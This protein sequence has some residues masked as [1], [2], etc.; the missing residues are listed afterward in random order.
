MKTYNKIYTVHAWKDN[1]KFFTVTQGEGGIKYP[2]LMVVDDKGAID[3]TG[4]A[5]TYTITLPRGSEEIVDAT[6]IDGKRGVVEFEVKPSMTVYAG[7]GEGEL[8]ITINNKVLKI[9]GINLTI[10]KSTSGHVIEA[11]EQFSAL[12]TLISKYSNINPE[13]KDLKILDNSDITDTA[14]NYPSIKYLLNNFWSNNNFSLLSATAYGVSNSGA[15]TSLLKIP[16]ASLSKR[17]LYFPAG[18]Y[19]CNGIVLSNIDDL[20]I[21]CDNANFVFYNQATNSTDA[22]ETTVQGSFFKFSNCNNL[23][24]IG[25]CFDGQHKVSQC[26]TLVGCQNSNITNAT[27]KGAGNKASSFAAGINLIRDCSQFNINN[28]IVSDIKAGTVSEDTFIHAVGIGVSS[29]NGEFSQHGYI[30]NSQISNING[31][32]VGNK[33]PDGDGIY[34]IQRPSADCSGDSYITVSNCTI[35]DCA[36]RGIKVSTRYTNID[37]CYI[38]IDG[39]GAA[40]EAQYGKMTLRDSTIH[41]KYASCVTL[42]WDN[43]T[44]YIDNCKL[45]GADKTETSTHGDKYTGN[46]IVLNQR[47]SVTG[48][49]YTNEPCSVI[50]RHCTIENVTSPLRSGYAAGLTYQYQSIIFD[51]CQIGHYRGA[52][53][54]MF[55]ASMISAINKLSL[56]DVNYKYGTTENEVQ[57]ANNQYFGLTNS[58]NTLDIGSTTYIKPNH[59]LY[60]NNL[61]DDY[62]KLFRMYD[63]LDSD[64]GA[65]KAN[66]SDVLEDAPNIL[67]CT[68]GTYTSKTNTHF[69]V[70]ATDNTLSIKCDT[71]YTSGK[72]FVYVKLDS[73]ELK[74]GTYNFYIDNITPVSSDVTITFADSSYNII[75]TSLELAL[76]K[77]SKSLIVDGVTKPITYLRVKLAANKTIDM[78]CTVS[79]ANRNKVLKG[80]LEARVAALEKII[81]TKE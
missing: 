70:V 18:T 37:N 67:S 27:I 19:K 74:G 33:E 66:V 3:L 79:L 21:I 7:V 45:Y 52:S 12:L 2:R 65:P 23:T 20:T 80:N 62:N 72:S 1:N 44:N 28:V 22:A 35:T 26:I 25:G 68:N 11:S 53:A 50:V 59:M 60:T 40:I 36:K 54:I 69:S 49:Y 39:W 5:V 61:T 24:I 47:L 15:V 13:N 77:A 17:C 78:Q 56:S 38:D 51:D 42:D 9:S 64:F 16:S 58:G 81:Q 48:T 34:L 8:N 75:D 55:D 46:G 4:S 14:K 76:N 29:V 10:N 31:Y 43:G 71:A 30:G 6:I 73:L 32:K 57:T 41:N 63:L